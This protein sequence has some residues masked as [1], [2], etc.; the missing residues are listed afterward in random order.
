MTE[1]LLGFLPQ[2]TD[3]FIAVMGMTGSG[4]STF[5][6]L[7]TGQDV[8]VGHNLQ[9]CT[10][11]VTVYKCLWSS[12]ADI[13]LFDTP[14][15]D[16]TNRSDTEVL[17]EIASCLTKI[18]EDNFKL[19]GIL[20]LHRIT[21][22]RIGGSA[23]RNLFM[24]RKLC[25]KDGLNNVL[26]VTTMWEDEQPEKGESREAELVATDGFW[27]AL[28][29]EGAEIKRHDNTRASAMA[30]LKIIAK[31]NRV[32]ISIQKEMVSEHKNLNETE[33]GMG[34]NSEI[35]LTEARVK[36]EMEMAL[37]M[38]REARRL[39][40]EESAEEQRQ[41]REKMQQR[42]DHLNQER[43][44]LKVSLEEMKEQRRLYKE[45][46]AKYK[47][48]QEL[49][50]QANNVS[51]WFPTGLKQTKEKTDERQ[52]IS[53]GTNG[54]WYYHY[55]IESECWTCWSDSL[56]IEYP[57][58]VKW[59]ES[60]EDFGCPRHISLGV[61]GFHYICM[62]NG[63]WHWKLPTR[64]A[65][66]IEAHT[67][68]RSND[69]ISRLWLG[70]DDDYVV[71]VNEHEYIIGVENYGSLRDQLDKRTTVKQLAMNLED[72]GGYILILGDGCIA[73][74]I[75]RWTYNQFEEH[76]LE[77]FVDRTR[78][79]GKRSRILSGS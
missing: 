76:K 51:G 68:K 3:I 20:Y 72:P 8:P 15:F 29:A 49:L 33:A 6:S 58:L 13:Y 2:P 23:K 50:R 19:S 78:L 18:Y 31:K 34:L 73:W 59:L 39:H 47:E 17:I 57:S 54:S 65:D 24:F 21:D 28:V 52:Y 32:A 61:G 56:A 16:D 62:M 75:G 70:Y 55:H 67:G 5:I 42:F 7:C 66:D 22:R 69:G 41:Y 53:L 45:L 12:S 60:L 10:Q 25:G 43:E 46:E 36:K 30:L 79:T 74:N 26:L 64:I 14:G 77:W 63:D 9:A 48:S 1:V 44:K 40:D 37:E 11:Q 4:K 71:E 27:G 35:L 38:E